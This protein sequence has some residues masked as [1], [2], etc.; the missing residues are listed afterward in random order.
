MGEINK[1]KK[2]NLIIDVAKCEDCNNCFLACKDEFTDNDFLPYSVAQPKHTHRWIDIV[3]KERGQ[4]PIVD[5]VNAPFL[6]MHCD[7]PLC[8]V[9]VKDGSVYKMDNGI[10]II[11]PERAKGQK[12]IVNRCPYGAIWWN[13]E[14]QVAQKCTL[15]VHLLNDGWKEPRC[16]QSCPT[17]AMHILKAEDSE[18]PEIIKQEHLDTYHP[19]YKTQPRV[20]YKNLYRF[21]NCFIAG[22]VA[23]E[24][25]GTID[26]AEGASI[27]LFQEE[28]KI[29]ETKT[30]IFG[31][32][33]L[34]NLS[35]KSG[36]Y[37]LKVTYKTF[38][39][40]VIK[41]DLTTSTSMGTILFKNEMD[42][43]ANSDQ[44]NNKQEQILTG[45]SSGRN[46]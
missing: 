14:K 28:K 15:C 43:S 45:Q 42:A 35:E 22:S 24:H 39:E 18:M 46:T 27:T 16:V 37:T 4:F 12:D 21:L 13:E 36:E 9:N 34:D 11:N 5:V 33:K 1:M 8:M 40:K 23:F 17:G 32:F 10:V 44:K 20:Y 2:W 30:D 25:E 7:N 3:T 41:I 38:H 6:C 19:E 31:D 29:K 26:C